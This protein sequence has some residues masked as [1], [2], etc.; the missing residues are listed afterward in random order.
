MQKRSSWW[1]KKIKDRDG[2][3]CL[4]CGFDRNL[5][6]HHIMPV[7]VYPEYIREDINGLTLNILKPTT[8]RVLLITKKAIMSRLSQTTTRSSKST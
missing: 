5:E 6:A 8:P 2:E 1:A 4:R 7:D 3:A